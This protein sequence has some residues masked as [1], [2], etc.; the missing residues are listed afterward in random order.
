M[1]SWGL[2]WPSSR[3]KPWCLVIQGCR[4]ERNLGEPCLCMCHCSCAAQLCQ[5]L[6]EM[7]LHWWGIIW[8][9]EVKI[10]GA[11][12]HREG[13]SRQGT[14]QRL[15]I[16]PV[17]SAGEKQTWSIAATN[18]ILSWTLQLSPVIAA[19]WPKLCSWNWLISGC[20]IDLFWMVAIPLTSL[21]FL[22]KEGFVFFI[23]CKIVLTALSL[24]YK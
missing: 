11:G 20:V 7:T 4:E 19:D 23:H 5:V 6:L 9:I 17:F 18:G 2:P 3:G 12:M 14:P 13:G 10:S 24:K 22:K 16:Y 1:Y 21:Q 8:A 15:F